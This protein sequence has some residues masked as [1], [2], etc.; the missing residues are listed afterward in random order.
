MQEEWCWKAAERRSQGLLAPEDPVQC[1]SPRPRI[2]ERAEG[3]LDIASLASSQLRR[4]GMDGQ[5]TGLEWSV[6]A[7]L[8]DDSGIVTDGWWWSLLRTVEGV[9]V[10]ALTPKKDKVPEG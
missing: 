3:V 10:E 5:V 9:L 2:T 4:A 1:L 7:R 8:A 6:V